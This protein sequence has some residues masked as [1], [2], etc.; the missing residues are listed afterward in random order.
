[1][2]VI[3]TLLSIDPSITL[4]KSNHVSKAFIKFKTKGMECLNLYCANYYDDIIN[5]HN[6]FLAVVWNLLSFI[7]TDDINYSKLIKELLDYYKIL[8]QYNRAEGFSYEIIQQ[9]IN[10]LVLT[11]MQMTSQEM[12]EFEDNPINFLKVELEEA[13][14]DSSNI[15]NF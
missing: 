13:D 3:K 2:N 1:M 9:L 10:T 5:Y 12:D 7:K 15:I 6:E 4:N 8:F 11:N 14:M